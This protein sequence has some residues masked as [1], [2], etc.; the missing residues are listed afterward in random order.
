[1]I[2]YNN[3]KIEKRDSNSIYAFL[4]S[5]L[6]FLSLSFIYQEILVCTQVFLLLNTMTDPSPSPLSLSLS[7]SH[8]NT[9]VFTLSVN[10][11]LSWEYES[12]EY[13]LISFSSAMR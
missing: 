12:G 1:M 6:Q 8:I 2:V 3:N 5:I 4:F 11:S 13:E 9:R 7:L 10:A